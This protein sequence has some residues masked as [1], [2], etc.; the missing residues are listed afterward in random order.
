VRAEVG[1]EANNGLDEEISGG[2]SEFSDK[3]LA[4][5]VA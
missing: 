5:A 1:I 2:T 4:V 3:L